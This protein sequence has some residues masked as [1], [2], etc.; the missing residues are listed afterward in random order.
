MAVSRVAKQEVGH[1]FG[2]LDAI[3]NADEDDGT[4]PEPT[5]VDGFRVRSQRECT[6]LRY[7]PELGIG[8]GP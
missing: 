4:E 2:T 5:Y 3:I 6:T 8:I 1:Y 7:A